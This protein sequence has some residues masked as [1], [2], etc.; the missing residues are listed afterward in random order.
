MGA[1]KKVSEFYATTEPSPCYELTN[2][3]S[4]FKL[5]RLIVSDQSTRFGLQSFKAIGALFAITKL[6]EKKPNLDV[7]CTATDGHHARAV[8]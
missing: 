4:F 1:E 5:N 6:L 2:V 7:F 3:A 8:A